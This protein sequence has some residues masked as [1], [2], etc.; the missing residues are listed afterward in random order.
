[1]I[2]FAT[3]D[4]ELYI[5]F[6]SEGILDLKTDRPGEDLLYVPTEANMEGDRNQMASNHQRFDLTPLTH[7]FAALYR[8]D[9]TDSWKFE[10]HLFNL[11]RGGL[12][13]DEGF[14]T[15]DAP[16]DNEAL[17]SYQMTGETTVQMNY[18]GRS[19]ACVVDD[20]G[21]FAYEAIPPVL[22]WYSKKQ[23]YDCAA[24][25]NVLLGVDV[26]SFLPDV[27]TVP[28]LG[29]VHEKI[30]ILELHFMMQRS[31]KK[32]AEE[33]LQLFGITDPVRIRVD[34]AEAVPTLKAYF[35]EHNQKEGN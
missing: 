9:G 18:G 13:F 35:R 11:N 21:P 10:L 34:N 26:L 31:A 6:Q 27:H 15:L 22:D 23:V 16:L 14:L 25:G 12:A 3:Q 19:Y 4:N 33:I 24:A 29:G 30:D 5:P 28:D 1:M 32:R 8:D 20:M 17:L 2:F 7:V